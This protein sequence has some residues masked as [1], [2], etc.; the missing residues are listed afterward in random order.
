M[1]QTFAHFLIL[2]S[3]YELRLP[4]LGE[5]EDVSSLGPLFPLTQARHPTALNTYHLVSYT[6]AGFNK[7]AVRT[8]YEIRHFWQSQQLLR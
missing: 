7:I 6:N 2:L 3:L 8:E 4:G 5:K 1:K